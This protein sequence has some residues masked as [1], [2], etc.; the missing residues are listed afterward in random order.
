MGGIVCLLC[1]SENQFISRKELL[2]ELL[3]MFARTLSVSL[4]ALWAGRCSSAEQPMILI[5][6]ITSITLSGAAKPF[7]DRTTDIFWKE[8]YDMDAASKGYQALSRIFLTFVSFLK[9]VF[10][11]LGWIDNEGWMDWFPLTVFVWSAPRR[12]GAGLFLKII[13]PQFFQRKKSPD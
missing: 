12:K 10:E 5:A 2:Y 6:I 1:F 3:L 4:T 11:R 7:P 8:N 13:A 9:T